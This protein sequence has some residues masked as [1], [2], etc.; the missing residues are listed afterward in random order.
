MTTTDH[1]KISVGAVGA[2]VSTENEYFKKVVSIM[3]GPVYKTELSKD[4]AGEAMN[5]VIRNLTNAICL[6]LTSSQYVFS[7][8]TSEIKAMPYGAHLKKKSFINTLNKATYQAGRSLAL[9]RY[10]FIHIHATPL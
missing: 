8:D 5:K 7:G 10:I 6:G 4:A 9:S 3:D 2:N 1:G